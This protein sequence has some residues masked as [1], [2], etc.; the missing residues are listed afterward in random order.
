MDKSETTIQRLTRE[1]RYDE[2]RL[3]CKKQ[4]AL[5]YGDD[6]PVLD[7]DGAPWSRDPEGRWWAPY[8]GVTTALENAA[9]T[10]IWEHKE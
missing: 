2:W 1:I 3:Q 9:L 5:L 4:Q 6:R 7:F 8:R 10:H